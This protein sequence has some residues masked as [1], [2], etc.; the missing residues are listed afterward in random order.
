MRCNWVGLDRHETRRVPRDR[1]TL[2]RSEYNNE[3][4]LP[5]TVARGVALPRSPLP[6]NAKFKRIV[7]GGRRH[8]LFERP[9]RGNLGSKNP[10]CHGLVRLSRRER[11]RRP[12]RAR[13][14]RSPYVVVYARRPRAPRTVSTR[15]IGKQGQWRSAR[16]GAALAQPQSGVNV[17]RYG[18]TY[19]ARTHAIFHLTCNFRE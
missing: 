3:A 2:S 12:I 7:T 1:E 4:L 5:R 15:K 11:S 10:T 17:R 16:N 8:A 6:A 18:P 9:S 14:A 13:E 19:E